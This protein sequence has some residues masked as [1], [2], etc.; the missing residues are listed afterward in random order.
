[1][2]FTKR[3]LTNIC[4]K[5]SHEQADDDVRKTL[6]VFADILAGDPGFTYRVMANSDIRVKFLMWTNGSSRMQYQYFGDEIT[7][8]TTYRTN[9]YD[10]PFD[11]FVHVNNHF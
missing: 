4:G 11:L 6:E 5:I 8:D 2:S 9:L 3:T 10:M 1:M 7:F